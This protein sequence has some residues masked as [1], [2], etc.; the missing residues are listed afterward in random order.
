MWWYFRTKTSF[1]SNWRVF[2]WKIF[3]KHTFP[4]KSLNTNDTVCISP[5]RFRWNRADWWTFMKTFRTKDLHRRTP[6]QTLHIISNGMKVIRNFFIVE[7]NSSVYLITLKTVQHEKY[8]TNES[9]LN[10]WQHW[11]IVAWNL[12]ARVWF[13][14]SKVTFIAF[15]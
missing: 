12:C 5:K 8:R 1:R 15:E 10:S 14:H 11:E 9:K 2:V 4:L 7:L 6:N 3:V 13:V